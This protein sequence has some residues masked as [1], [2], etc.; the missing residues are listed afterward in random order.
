MKPFWQT[1]VCRFPS[2]GHAVL[3]ARLVDFRFLEG[4][5]G[6]SLHLKVRW[7]L[8]PLSAPRPWH[9]C[10]G[11]GRARAFS[12]S[13]KARLNANSQRLDAWL[14][15]KCTSCNATWN[16]PVFERSPVKSVP[17]ALLEAMEAN[18]S[19]PLMALACNAGRL[20]QHSARIDPPEGVHI[21]SQVLQNARFCEDAELSLVN[22]SGCHVRL[23]RLL[24]AALGVPRSALQGYMQEGRLEVWPD[25]RKVLSRPAR[26]GQTIMLRQMPEEVRGRLAQEAAVPA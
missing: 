6:M 4:Q 15:Y 26:D 10:G 9:M 20:R 13:G 19:A 14:I 2:T 16:L 23:D 1:A 24:G 11:C 8:T 17:P 5:D 25:T 12:F 3:G 21:V 18:L 22:T 7:T